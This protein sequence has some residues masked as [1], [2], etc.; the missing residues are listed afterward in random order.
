MLQKIIYEFVTL[1]VILDAVGML[2]IFLAV[3][4][5]FDAAQRRKIALLS[6]LYAYL[7]L[8]VFIVAGEL[9]LIT[10]GV[11][12]RAFQIAGGILLLLYGIEMTLGNSARSDGYSDIAGNGLNSLAVYPLAIPAI[13]GPG[14][15][16]TVVLLTDNRIYGVFDQVITA[17]VL[18]VVLAVFLIILLLANPIMRAIGDGGANI[19]RRVMG[20]ILCAIAVKMALGAVQGWLNLPAL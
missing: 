14:A 6:I 2:A 3:T 20:V 11:P 7:V 19:L 9:L 1:F 8:L 18:G 16:L 12:L 5:G 17:L 13:A 4:A 10:M 15:M